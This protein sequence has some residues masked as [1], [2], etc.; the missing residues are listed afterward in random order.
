MQQAFRGNC[1]SLPNIWNGAE[2][3]NLA[4]YPSKK[5]S[6]IGRLSMSTGEPNVEEMRV[7]I[8]ANH[9][10][11]VH[12]SVEELAISK[13]SFHIILTA[14][15]KTYCITGKSVPCLSTY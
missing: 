7:V 6:K 9:V 1:L 4:E 14:N 5:D 8:R 11:N 10:L 12:E 13:D 3:S 15:M 2:V